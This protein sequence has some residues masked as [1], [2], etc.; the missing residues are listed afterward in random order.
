[1]SAEEVASSFVQ[2]F[3]QSFDANVDSLSGLFVSQIGSSRFLQL[4]VFQMIMIGMK[5]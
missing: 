3:Y 2:H 1:M 5:Y 4:S